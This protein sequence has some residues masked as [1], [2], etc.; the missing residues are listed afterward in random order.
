MNIAVIGLGY[1]GVV[2]AA[3]L[4]SKGHR[5]IG[6]DVSAE[7]VDALN[8]GFSPILEPG[9]DQMVAGAFERSRLTATTELAEALKHCQIAIICVGTP[10]LHS[11]GIDLRYVREVAASI[12]QFLC[13]NPSELTVVFRSTMVPGS[14]RELASVLKEMKSPKAR[15]DVVFCPEFLREGSA[16]RDFEAPGL[17]V[18]GTEDGTS[19]RLISELFGQVSW[20]L[21]EEAET[22]KYACN[23]W[24]AVKVSFANE[25]GRLCST[26]RIDGRTVMKEFCKDAILNISPYYLRPGNP[27]GGSCL[28]KDVSALRHFSEDR[29]VSTP[30]LSAVSSS[31]SAHDAHLLQ[32]VQST[33][34]RR[35]LLLGLAFKNNTDDMRGSPMV[36]LAESL[37]SEG[38]EVKFF[39]PKIKPD[40]LIGKNSTL[41]RQRVPN[42]DSL[43][44]HDLGEAI[45]FA[46][47]IVIPYRTVDIEQ[48]RCFVRQ[49]QA[50][51]DVNG[52]P[53]LETLDCKY[54]GLCW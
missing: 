15:I 32:T 25:I 7:K 53:E 12:G 16:I 37:C 48:L 26:L 39:D 9:V 20:V 18:A 35:I 2:T 1:V 50:I 19:S 46:E 8:R 43:Q 22:V 34:G 47:T 27:Y 4:A 28:P 13:E 33:R 51:V 6:V 38:V 10:Q 5:I 23:F 3:C 31:N 11:G 14:T 52:W 30:L 17:S 41:I 49:D 44:F 29:S 36:T 42:L 24:H 45:A 21:W 54:S 40:V